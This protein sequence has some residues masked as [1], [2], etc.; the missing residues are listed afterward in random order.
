L[1]SPQQTGTDTKPRAGKEVEAKDV[2]MDRYQQADGV[3]AVSHTSE[4]QSP[5]HTDLVDEG[6]AKEAEDRE[7]TV[8][9][10]VLFCG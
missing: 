8:E 6:S 9:R 2:G 1:G 4:S 5:F 7:S 10:G 3:D